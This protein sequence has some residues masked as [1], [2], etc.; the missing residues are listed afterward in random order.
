MDKSKAVASKPKTTLSNSKTSFKPI[1][2]N[3]TRVL[4]SGTLP[5]DQS[6]LQDQYYANS[7]NKFWRIIA[8][9]TDTALPVAYQG[10]LGSI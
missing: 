6:L 1:S 2:N 9:I 8:T 5:G 3:Q 7:R 4:I 10:K